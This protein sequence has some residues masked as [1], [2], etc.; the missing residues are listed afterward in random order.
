MG[1]G[2]KAWNGF[3]EGR[4]TLR[5]FFVSYFRENFM[6]ISIDF[7]Y[8]YLLWKSTSSRSMYIQT[9]VVFDLHHFPKIVGRGSTPYHLSSVIAPAYRKGENRGLKREGGL[10]SW[11]SGEHNFWTA[12]SLLTLSFSYEV[13][14]TSNYIRTISVHWWFT[15]SI[16]PWNLFRQCRS[17]SPPV[18]RRDTAGQG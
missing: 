17:N 12:I 15:R 11:L 7:D 6:Y 10:G 8:L 4:M 3:W 16:K 1:F 18:K 9:A 14:S 2:Y 5:D 13:Y